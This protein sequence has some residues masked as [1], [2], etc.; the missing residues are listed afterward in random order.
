MEAN[1]T[2]FEPGPV[3]PQPFSAGIHTVPSFDVIERLPPAAQE[4]S[5]HCA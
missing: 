5:A 3:N 1:I 2:T 4:N